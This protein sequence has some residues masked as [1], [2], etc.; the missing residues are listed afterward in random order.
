MKLHM[1][2]MNVKYTKGKIRFV[3]ATHI[4]E[5][6]ADFEFGHEIV[7]QIHLVSMQARSSD[8]FYKYIASIEF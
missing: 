3:D 1:T 7:N 4:L 2:V 8:G 6:Y 5:Q